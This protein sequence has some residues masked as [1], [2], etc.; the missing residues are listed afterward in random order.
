MAT[1]NN[2]LNEPDTFKPAL[3][4][5]FDFINCDSN[6]LKA[7]IVSLENYFLQYVGRVWTVRTT[8]VW[9][10]NS[11][12]FWHA[13]FVN[14]ACQPCAFF[15]AGGTLWVMAW[16]RVPRPSPTGVGSYKHQGKGFKDL[17]S[18]LHGKF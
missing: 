16:G 11:G 18:F 7:H 14:P 3:I 4:G 6:V 9:Q 5:N 8:V 12:P 10:Q 15:L 17:F 13:A 2:W 1:T